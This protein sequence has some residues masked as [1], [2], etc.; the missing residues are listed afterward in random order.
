MELQ[1]ERN[2]RKI[3]ARKFLIARPALQ[4]GLFLYDFISA[5]RGKQL[6]V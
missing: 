5:G 1:G 3:A 2:R 6:R 4:A